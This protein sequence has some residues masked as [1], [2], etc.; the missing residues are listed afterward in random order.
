ASSC[1][2]AGA[3][4]AQRSIRP[5]RS[6]QKVAQANHT[7]APAN[8]NQPAANNRFPPPHRGG[9]PGAAAV[10]VSGRDGGGVSLGTGATSGTLNG[11]ADTPGGNAMGRRATNWTGSRKISPVFGSSNT[12]G[13]ISTRTVTGG[14]G[15]GTG[16]KAGSAGSVS[17]CT[18]TS[19][20]CSGSL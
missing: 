19:T 7:A 2:S 6:K 16:A 13:L 5:K 8:H 17:A 18:V 14:R 11:G 20:R 10:A 1:N 15:T 3:G 4:T 9:E 12:S